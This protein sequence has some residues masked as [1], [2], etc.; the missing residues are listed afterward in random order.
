MLRVEVTDPGPG[1][2]PEMDE[3]TPGQ[4]GGWGLFLTERLAD[5][6]GVDRADGLTTV[7]MEMDLVLSDTA[8]PDPA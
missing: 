4:A 6:W 2:D 7:W 5:R 1:F 3:P 8:A